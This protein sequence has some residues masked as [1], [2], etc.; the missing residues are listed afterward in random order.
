MNKQESIDIVIKI[1]LDS[2]NIDELKIKKS[3]LIE[4]LII[5][6]KC[7]SK[8]DDILSNS[9]AYFSQISLE[10]IKNEIQDIDWNMQNHTIGNNTGDF[11]LE[12]PEYGINLLRCCPRCTDYWLEK[13]F[14]IT[15]L[16]GKILDIKQTNPSSA[17]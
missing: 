4:R 5:L 9:D 11:W 2:K 10:K 8:N 12:N 6:T 7:D 3:M 13:L 1:I 17:Q 15:F 14:T 16:K